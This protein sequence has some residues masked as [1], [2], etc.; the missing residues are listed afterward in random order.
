[1][2]VDAERTRVY[3]VRMLYKHAARI[4][5]PSGFQVQR[6]AIRE[7]RR[8]STALHVHVLIVAGLS[9]AFLDDDLRLVDYL[10]AYV[11]SHTYACI[12]DLVV[13]VCIGHKHGTVRVRDLAGE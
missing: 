9:W 10:A 6:A 5:R 13:F 3:V 12:V 4:P 11:G 7:T 2:R 1:M 8:A